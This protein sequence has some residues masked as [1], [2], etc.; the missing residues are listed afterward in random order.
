MKLELTERQE[1]AVLAVAGFVVSV[2][3]ANVASAQGMEFLT[4]IKSWIRAAFDDN[5][6]ALI[7]GIW[8]IFHLGLFCKT[9]QVP[10]LCKA[11]GGGFA[12]AIWVNRYSVL[13]TWGV[14]FT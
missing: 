12:A 8:G 6:W 4:G 14:N 9:W 7:P 5:I 1:A 2:L 3:A 13:T 11:I 10:S